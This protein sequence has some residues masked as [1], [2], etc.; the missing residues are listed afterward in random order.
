MQLVLQ[1]WIKSNSQP[2]KRQWWSRLSP[3]SPWA[4]CRAMEEL[5]VHQWICLKE[6]QPMESPCRSSIGQSYSP[7]GEACSGAGGLGELPPIRTCVDQCMKDGP[8][9]CEALQGGRLHNL[10]GQLISVLH[11]YTVK[12]LFLMLEHFVFQFVPITS[13][14]GTWHH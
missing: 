7:W 6:V 5:M 13:Y 3:C 12:K 1:A 14:P 11:Y 10:P 2:R 9:D 8:H 4:P